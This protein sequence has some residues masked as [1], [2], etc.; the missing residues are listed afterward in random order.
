MALTWLGRSLLKKIPRKV[1]G[2]VDATVLEGALGM[3][4]LYT[5]GAQKYNT[6]ALVVDEQLGQRASASLSSSHARRRQ[7]QAGTGCQDILSWLW[8]CLSASPAPPPII[9]DHCLR[10]SCG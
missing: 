4:L 7:G 9:L 10:S 6:Q 2:L 8:Q 5:E 3:G 1:A